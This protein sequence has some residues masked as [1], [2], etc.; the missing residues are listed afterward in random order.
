MIWTFYPTLLKMK[1]CKYGA[2]QVTFRYIKHYHFD[3]WDTIQIQ[4][5]HFASNFLRIDAFKI[6]QYAFW[7][8]GFLWL[9]RIL[10][11][12][13]SRMAYTYEDVHH[14]KLFRNPKPC[15]WQTRKRLTCSVSSHQPLSLCSQEWI[16]PFLQTV[17][18]LYDFL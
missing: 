4:H 6:P 7:T 18:N 5:Y 12:L 15:P 14:P 8:H 3:Q 1:L 17:L 13:C 2:N 9:R 10:W 16:M 11:E